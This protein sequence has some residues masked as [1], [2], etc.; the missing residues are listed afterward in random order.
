MHI[1]FVTGT[2]SSIL[3]VVGNPQEI[4]TL[5]AGE[6][7]LILVKLRLSRVTKADSHIRE[8][9]TSEE[10]I[11]DLES[12]LGDVISSYLTVRLTYMH[13][14]FINR[15]AHV[16]YS[17]SSLSSHVTKIQTQS[18]AF[19]KRLNL[20][21]AWSPHSSR[22]VDGPLEINPLIRLVEIYYSGE[23]AIT[24][25][26]KL[27]NDKVKVPL[28][29]RLVGLNHGTT[30][31]TIPSGIETG[32]M[33]R[34]DSAVSMAISTSSHSQSENSE[35]NSSSEIDPAR[36]I[37]SEMRKT[38]KGHYHRRKSVSAQKLRRIDDADDCS[39]SRLSSIVTVDDE[40]ARIRDTAL[41][42]KR[43]VGAD[44]LRS[45]APSCHKSNAGSIGRLGLG[46]GKSWGWGGGWWG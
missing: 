37:W 23:K 20:Q 44:T 3:D 33:A 28:A 19:I 29:R 2:E 38:S 9:S 8:S 5:C 16:V 30:E 13:S 45:I 11:A 24:A 21:S 15:D 6:K 14:G 22:I 40:R 46:A 43:S 17:G 26:Q 39:P 32:I 1:A 25:L 41:R 10:L 4:Q 31:E 36:K 42:N 12:H 34:I 27:K 7:H 35:W 18:S